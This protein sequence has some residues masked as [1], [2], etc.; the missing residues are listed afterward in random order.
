[1]WIVI[2][3]L[4]YINKDVMMYKDPLYQRVVKLDYLHCPCIPYIC[5]RC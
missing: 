3:F 5:S 1:M 4:N 2:R